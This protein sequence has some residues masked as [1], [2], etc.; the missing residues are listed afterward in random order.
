MNS[1][2]NPT[3]IGAFV[4]G[5]IFLAVVGFLMFGSGRFFTDRQLY[6]LYFTGS[7]KGL[8]VGAP[9]V[10]R[11]V[12]VGTVTDIRIE[13]DPQDLSF[14]IP[15]Y[16]ELEPEKLA[17]VKGEPSGLHFEMQSTAVR[18]LMKTLVDKGLR[19][20]LQLQ[21]FVT[22]QLLI[23]LDFHPDKPLRLVGAD[24]HAIELP[25]IPS[26]FQQISSTLEKI[27]VEEL[28]KK[29][30][31][32]LDGLERLVNSPDLGKSFGELND[33]LSEVRTL[34]HNVDSRMA[35]FNVEVEKTLQDA[36]QLLVNIDAK[37]E[38][39]SNSLASTTEDIHKALEQANRTLA[40]IEGSVSENSTT[41]Y[42]FVNTLEEVGEAARSLRILSDYLT[43]NPDALL[44]GKGPIGDS[45]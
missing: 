21:S 38:P 11:G 31:D 34:V 3:F 15:V 16:V 20:Q 12:G 44:R 30:A 14:R 33:T 35:T 18:K 45:K 9:V 4:L 27:P 26:N 25:T 41:H 8:Q 17:R 13:M 19:G 22:G 7:V 37:V 32:T 6:V 39:A 40:A 2:L 24:D 1:K 5:G 43:Q 42:E 23:E 36:Q 29:F 28:A 10:F